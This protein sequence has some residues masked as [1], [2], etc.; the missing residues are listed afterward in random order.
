ML[1]IDAW[2]DEKPYRE[3]FDG[4]IH[5]KVSPRVAHS[6]VCLHAG[7]LL[8]DWAGRR[9]VVGVEMRVYLEPGVTLVPDVAFITLDRL[10]ALSGEARQKP[11][12]APDIV[13]EVRS[14]KDRESHIARKTT[15][16]LAHG[17]TLILNVDPDSRTILLT[18]HER[19]RTLSKVTS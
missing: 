7:R 1:S 3:V 18:S 2:L 9:G 13:I 17:A 8:S 16:Y 6:L 12:F 4:A 5:E 15:L 19:E 10:K 11:P 14:P